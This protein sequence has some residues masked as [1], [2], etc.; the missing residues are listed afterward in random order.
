MPIL[1]NDTDASGPS[2]RQVQHALTRQHRDEQAL[3]SLSRTA[4]TAAAFFSEVDHPLTDDR[5][6][7]RAVLAH[8]VVWHRHY[9]SIARALAGGRRPHLVPEAAMAP[10]SATDRGCRDEPLPVLAAQL[11]ALQADLAEA[12]RAVSDWGVAFPL[13]PGGRHRSVRDQVTHIEA[14]IRQHVTRLRRVD[15]RAG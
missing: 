3:A 5:Q 13:E 8:L 12:L 14:H 9:V 15:R 4:A 6:T 2:R 7:A 11:I 1:S 10:E